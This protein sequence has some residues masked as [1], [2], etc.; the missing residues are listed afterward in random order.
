M[1]T[2][3]TAAL[4]AAPAPIVVTKVQA[5]DQVKTISVACAPT[6]SMVAIGQ[7][8]G[9]V[10]LMN[11]ATRQTVKQLVGHPQ[12]CYGLAFSPDGKLLVSGDE[13]SRMYV[14]DIAK[15][16]KLREFPRG[17]MSHGRGIQAISFSKDGKTM[18]STGKD[19][20][21]IFWDFATMKPK[22]R[23]AGN[24]VVFGSAT[25]VPTGM[26]IAT[27]TEGVHFRLP[28]T[29]GLLSQR[30]GH[31][32]Q[33]VNELAVNAAG[34]KF[35]T[36]GRD[37]ALGVWNSKDR[38]RIASLKGHTD[39]VQH[40]AI[41]PNGRLAA[42]SSNDRF[43][44]LWDLN[45]FK[46][47]AKLPDQSAIGAPLAFTGDGK[48]LISGTVNDGLQINSITPPQPAVVPKTTRRRR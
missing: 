48:F 32:G 2:L 38:L 43:V 13:T 31:G 23:V 40:C 20:V 17:V 12:A 8:N 7:E 1:I 11:A 21:V 16:T 27:L 36:A 29:Y 30:D 39:W 45:T 28:G 33:G 24:G 14:W 4:I 15:G 37:N 42:S 44:I 34:T 18:I 10:R 35:V 25:L 5:F 22:L 26:V 41:S 6:G 46:P 19:D 47:I 9:Q 3:I